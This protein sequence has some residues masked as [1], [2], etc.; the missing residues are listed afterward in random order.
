MN[1]NLKISLVASLNTGLSIGEINTS[2]RGIEK[3]IS[4][5]KLNIQIND[6]VLSTLKNFSKEM[7]KL[8]EIAKNTG[9]VIEESINPDGSRTKRTYFNGLKG[10]FSEIT[11]AAKETGKQQLSSLDEVAN[12]WDKVTKE[13]EKYNAAQQKIGGKTSLSNNKG[14]VQ[15][16]VNTN[17]DGNVIGYQDTYNYAKDEQDTQK[18]ISAKAKL[19]QELVKLGE[20]GNLTAQQLANVAKVVNGIKDI[21]GVG[22]ANKAVVSLQDQAKLAEQMAQGREKASLASAQAEDKLNVAQ[23]QAINKNAEIT[24]QLQQQLQVYQ[25][26]AEIQAKGLLNNKNKILSPDQ[27]TALNN[28]LTSVKGLN[29]QT[30]QLQQRMQ[31]LG[32]DFKEISVNSRHRNIHICLG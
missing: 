29:I 21:S 16:T 32:L 20:T 14:T 7:S 13:V 5:L 26:Q 24:R 11:K 18:V 17:A 4:A 19:R 23:Q 9:K 6:N 8:G 2:I 25:R 3:K 27:V 31:Q 12:G 30:P 22:Q 10:E 15:R 28:Y 1:N